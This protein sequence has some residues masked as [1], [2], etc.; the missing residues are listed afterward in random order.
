MKIGI[1]TFHNVVNYGGVLQCYALQQKLREWGYEAE[2][3]NYENEYFKKF[4]SP[5]YVTKPYLRKFLYMLYAFR[6]KTIRRKKFSNFVKENIILSPQCFNKNTISN[7]NTL[8]DVFITGSDQVWNLELT[9]MDKNYF[10]DFVRGKKKISYAA[11]IG[12]AQLDEEKK[13]IYKKLLRDFDSISVR[14]NSAS[15]IINDLL[16]QATDVH[17][18]PVLLL[19]KGAWS[20]ICDKS[21]VENDEEYIVVYKIN[22]SKAYDA[23]EYLAKM[24]GI[25]VKVIQ[26]DKTCKV[27]FQKYKMASPTDFVTLFK[28]ARYVITDSFH[29][30]VFSIIFQKQ[31][32]YFMDESVNNRN[33]R[34]QNL[35]SKLNLQSRSYTDIE[36]VEFLDDSIDYKSVERILNEERNKSKTYLEQAIQ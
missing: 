32:A 24:K 3:I 25:K 5:F 30:T 10:L 8:Y 29:G 7:A 33:S 18:D 28:N 34:I 16:G 31:F 27:G 26:P 20:K 2:V 36:Q 11:S 21:V 19:D 17:I 12:L 9:E 35:L 23:A 1:I 13:A 4:Y 22:K 6:Q 15:N 14:E